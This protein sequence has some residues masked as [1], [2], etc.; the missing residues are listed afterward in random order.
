M[1]AS[2]SRSPSTW[3]KTLS[4]PLPWTLPVVSSVAR[5]FS[6][7]VPPSRSPSV[8]LPLGMYHSSDSAWHSTN[9]I[10]VS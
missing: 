1:A 6:T 7:L 5:R 10:A 3:V 9:I 8:P 4:V 2:F